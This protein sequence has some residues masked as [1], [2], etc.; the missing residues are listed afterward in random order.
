M[1]AKLLSV[2]GID[3]EHRAAVELALKWHR[4]GMDFADAIH[5]ASSDT[6]KAFASFDRPMAK[7]ATKAGAKPKVI[8]P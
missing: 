8:E 6:A 3:V 7:A 4:R 2:P 1:K 5:L